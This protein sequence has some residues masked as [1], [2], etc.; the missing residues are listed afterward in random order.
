[1]IRQSALVVP[2]PQKFTHTSYAPE[3][4]T[5]KVVLSAGASSAVT[6]ADAKTEP[7][8]IAPARR[9]HWLTAVPGT[10]GAPVTSMVLLV[11]ASTKIIPAGASARR[12]R[13]PTGVAT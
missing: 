9:C 4:R 11:V 7:P 3:A 1:M 8:F 12:S 5:E 6:S 10:S 2:A 13:R